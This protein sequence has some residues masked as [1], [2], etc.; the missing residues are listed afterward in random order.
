M[1]DEKLI[2]VCPRCGSEDFTYKTTGEAAMPFPTCRNCDYTDN[3]VEVP[4]ETQEEIQKKYAAGKSTVKP[5]FESVGPYPI[6]TKMYY[7][8]I[9][10][11]LGLVLLAILF[12]VMLLGIFGIIDLTTLI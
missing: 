4:K 6:W 1:A 10:L 2:K 3:F 7:P 12:I 5:T 8:K 9:L 11:K